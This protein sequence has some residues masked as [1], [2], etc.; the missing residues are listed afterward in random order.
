MQGEFSAESEVNR[1]GMRVNDISVEFL[2]VV[3]K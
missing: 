3:L 2:Y 1:E